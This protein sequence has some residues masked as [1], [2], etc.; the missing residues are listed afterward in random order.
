MAIYLV[1]HGKAAAGSEHL[2]PGLD[3]TGRQQAQLMAEALRSR[4]I[5]RLVVSPML[6][7]RETMAP[8]ADVLAMEPEVRDEVSEVFDPSMPAD[9]RRVMIGPFMQSTWG[10]QSHDLRAW[11]RR[12]VEA[13]LDMG[14]EAADAG[15]DLVIVSH[16][17]A[18]CTVIGKAMNDDRVVPVPVANA[19]ISSVELVDR[20]F[21][22]LSAGA[23]AHL[24][25]GL[26]T[27]VNTA[28]MGRGP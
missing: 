10:A 14:G 21:H 23:T 24:P 6:R 4:R 19:S 7:C 12:C 28:I 25:P 27:G 17:I 15:Q 5:G 18:I 11:R 13:V 3:E 26:V 1:R 8:L 2:D 16:Y 22:L 9:D 20:R